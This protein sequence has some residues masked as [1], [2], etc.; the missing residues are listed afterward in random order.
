MA[1]STP[2]PHVLV[3]GDHPSAYLAAAM[4]RQADSIRV[5]L[6]P[7]PGESRPDR[8]VSINPALFE[9]DPLL[10]PLR[11][12]LEMAS[13]YG[14]KFLADDPATS[15]AH[16][17]KSVAAYIGSYKQ[18]HAAF[19]KLAESAKAVFHRPRELQ[20]R[21]IDESCVE[22]ALDHTIVRPKALIVAGELPAAARRMIGL[23]ESW[24]GEVPHR[25]TYLKLE[26][27][28]WHDAGAK[29]LIPMSLDLKGTLNWGWL[30]PGV[31]HVQ[32]AVDQPLTSV[33]SISSRQL[34]QHWVRV[35][36]SHGQLQVGDEDLHWERAISIDLPL[37]GALSQEGVANR[38]LLIGPA[39]G[40]FTAC[41]EEVY[42]ACWSAVHAVAVIIKALK[43]P[44][45]QDALQPY[46]QQW[47]ATLGDYLR[48]PQQNLRFL[49]PLVY[50]NSIMTARL[51]EAILTGKS[52][53]R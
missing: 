37:A 31:D 7:I 50:R 17:G 9:L 47:G 12:K 48:G 53:V 29:P 43:E 40:F 26:G 15:I 23:P 52:V 25:Y 39:G 22:V 4:L 14:L 36:R 24:D 18:V 41:A 34:L 11:R 1:K 46:R 6:A 20:I 42:P 32:I 21:N 44:H 10:A 35:L 5:A 30:L 28:K 19:Q 3:L 27:T 16:V 51:T 8:L 2:Q 13:I 33:P 49:L 38:A 45:L